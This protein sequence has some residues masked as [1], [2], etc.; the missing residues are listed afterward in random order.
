MAYIYRDLYRG[1]H[2]VSSNKMHEEH[3]AERAH[4]ADGD[5]TVAISGNFRASPTACLPRGYRCAG[6]QCDRLGESFPTVR[7]TCL[8]P[9]GLYISAHRVSSN[10][11]HEEH[12]AERAH[13]ADGDAQDRLQA[14]AGSGRLGS[15]V[16]RYLRAGH[17]AYRHALRTVGKLSSRRSF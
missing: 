1:A 7:S 16:D 10:E 9:C 13:G 15:V 3:D 14:H 11:M 5:T 2:R 6:T 4:G 12:D 8:Y 17:R